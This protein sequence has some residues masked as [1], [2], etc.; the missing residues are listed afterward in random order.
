MLPPSRFATLMLVKMVQ[1]IGLHGQPPHSCDL[2]QLWEAWHARA[3]PDAHTLRNLTE[4]DRIRWEWTG[5]NLLQRQI[6][7]NRSTLFHEEETGL[8]R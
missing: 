5:S 7:K 3:W 8:S 4:T 2:I 1:S 6:H